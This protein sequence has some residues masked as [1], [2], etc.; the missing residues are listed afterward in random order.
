MINMNEMMKIILNKESKKTI[1]CLQV[2]I[3]VNKTKIISDCN[4][5]DEDAM[6]EEIE[7]NFLK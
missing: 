4:I 1:C 5:Y 6:S 3:I 2:D 7:I